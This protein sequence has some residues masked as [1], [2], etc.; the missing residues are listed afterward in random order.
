MVMKCAIMQP[1]YLPWAGYFNLIAQVDVFVFLDD[2]QHERQSW[3]S[4]NRI[5]L[6]NQPY[7]ISLP[8]KRLTHSQI[9]N[10]IELDDMRNWRRKHL[11]LLEQTY[12]KHPYRREILNDI[13]CLSDKSINYL[14]DLNIHLVRKFS[15]SLGLTTSFL[16]ASDL[17]IGGKRSEHLYKICD[18]LNCDTYLSPLGSKEYLQEDRVF[19]NSAIKLLFQEYE[20]LPYPQLKCPNFISHLSIIDV[21]A[22]NGWHKTLEYVQTGKII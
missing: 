13:Q 19:D 17:N 6:N 5:L 2:V 16:R 18:Y 9:I 21:I 20:P 4:R 22:N 1:T 11:Q 15:D 8:V 14:A 12:S 3:Q 10:T 7:W